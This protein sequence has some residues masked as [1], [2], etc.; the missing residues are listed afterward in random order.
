MSMS[1]GNSEEGKLIESDVN[2][3]GGTTKE[4]NPTRSLEDIYQMIG[5]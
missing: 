2:D 3:Y 4:E 1:A 5:N